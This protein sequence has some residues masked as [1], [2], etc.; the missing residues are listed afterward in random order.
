MKAKRKKIPGNSELEVMKRCRR[1][2]CVC[3]GLNRDEK[4]KRG[5]IAHLDWD[6]S[7]NRIENLAFMCLEHHDLFDTRTSQSRSFAIEEVKLY[8]RELEDRYESWQFLKKDTELLNLLADMI[9]PE[10]IANAAEKIAGR[11]VFYGRGLAIE[12]LTNKEIEYVDMDLYIPLLLALG[13]FQSWG[14]LAYSS[15]LICGKN[16][17]NVMKIKIKHENICNEIANILAS[18]NKTATK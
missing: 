16:G 4:I 13:H 14:L 7:N 9:D 8:K 11:Y 17:I 5:Q 10:A 1:R 2:C 15:R 3:Y 12:A 6:P 18:R